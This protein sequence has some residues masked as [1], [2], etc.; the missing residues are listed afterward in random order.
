MTTSQQYD[1][2]IIGSG[3]AG[4]PLSTTLA[5]AGMRTALI[6]REHVG[7]TCVNEGCTPTKTMVASGRVAY[8]ARRGA[9]YGVHTGP[10]SI[11]LRKVRERKRNIVDSFRS[12]SQSRIEKTANLE[13]IFGLA[14]F[15]GPKSVE[16]R[17]KDGSQRVL[18]ANKIFINAGTRASR[19]KLDGLESIPFLDNA[20]IMELDSVPDHLLILGGGYIGLEFGQL[21]RRFGGRVTIIQSAGQLLTGEDADIAEEVAKILRR[22]GVEIL[23]KAKATRVRQSDG[24][25]QL[26]VQQ[27]GNLTTL[28][29]SHLLV[30]TGRLPNSDTLNLAAAGIQVNDRGF[31]QVNDRLETTAD[32]VYALGDIKGGP[33]FTH[34]SY[35]DFR[36]IR[37]NLLEKKPASVANR[38]VPYTLFIDPQLGRVGL[39]ETEARAQNRNIRVAKLPM[40]SVAR[41]LEVDETRGSMKAIVDAETN[42]ILGAAILGIEGGEVMSA[43]EIAMI[44]K[45]PYTALRDGVFA[46]PT[47]AESLNSLFIA[48]ESNR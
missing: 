31:I 43:I 27:Q 17:L 44:G 8:L 9:E 42:L 10:I 40:T 12:S 23:L 20:S 22:D 48:M 41:A 39:T 3:Q 30:A 16:V 6:E 29:G 32:G 46:H 37:A 14:S 24:S 36:I 13:L 34:I 47:L 21:F 38:L 28:A 5:Q 33:A 7:G 18:S 25:I 26:E 19:P 45:L 2:V 11:D 1:A 15:T 4:T 35:D